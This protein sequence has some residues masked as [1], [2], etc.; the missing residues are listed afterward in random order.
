MDTCR[1]SQRRRLFRR[2]LGV[3]RGVGSS[4]IL[5]LLVSTNISAAISQETVT[6]SEPER[7]AQSAAPTPA[8]L[9]TARAA[10]LAGQVAIGA[11]AYWEGCRI[12]GADGLAEYWRDFAAVATEA[13]RSAWQAID[14]LAVENGEKPA[15]GACDLLKLAWSRRAALTGKST[16]DRLALHYERLRFARQHYSLVRGRVRLGS[17]TRLLSMQVGRP[18]ETGLDDRGLMFV[19]LGEPDR[20]TTFSG[21]Q[22]RYGFVSRAASRGLEISSSCYHPNESWAYEFPDGNRVYH[23]SPLEGTADWWLLENLHDVY[24]CGD[25]SVAVTILDGQVVSAGTLSPVMGTRYAPISQVAWLVLGDLYMSRSELDPAFGTLAN[26]IVTS[27]PDDSGRIED[28]RSLSPNALTLQGEFAE[29]RQTNFDLVKEALTQSLD[30]P[31]VRPEAPILFELLQFREP[32]RDYE[33]RTR[34]V[35]NAVVQADPLT[36]EP[37]EDGGVRYRVHAMISLVSESGELHQRQAIFALRSPVKLGAGTGVPLRLSLDV[38]PGEY[39]YS[40]VV[41]DASDERVRPTGN[42]KTESILVHSYGANVPQLSDIAFAADSGGSWTLPGGTALPISPVHQT[43]REGRAWL[44]FEAYGLSQS[45][46]YEVDVQLLPSEGGEAFALSF[47]GAPPEAG[48]QAVRR[49]LQL[50]LGDTAPG[51][52]GLTIIVTDGLGR[53]SLPLRTDLRVVHKQNQRP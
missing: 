34:V 29:E 38:P 40:F 1:N 2:R 17:R 3:L 43:N 49:L 15:G 8:S 30:R 33:N 14:S 36:A 35:L 48:Q 19:R 46:E 26:R 7:T 20:K 45:G 25:P 53:R 27:R 18:E 47:R 22:G 44:Y 23:F 50:E 21:L 37:A 51:E 39:E 41:R 16:A 12:A 11:D 31:A 10:F 32:A 6:A 5:A 42:W 4:I 28:M 9:E 13:E 24:G 52:Y